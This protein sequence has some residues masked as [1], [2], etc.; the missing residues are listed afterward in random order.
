MNDWLWHDGGR[1]LLQAGAAALAGSVGSS[2][3]TLG[4]D[5][6]AIVVMTGFAAWFVRSEHRI[7]RFEGGIAFTG[8]VMLSGVTVERG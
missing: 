7:V 6:V 5:L 8:C 3:H 1:L 2:L 4:V